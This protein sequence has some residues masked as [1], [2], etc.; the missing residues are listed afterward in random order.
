MKSSLTGA[1]RYSPSLRVRLLLAGVLVQTVM[2]ALLIVNGINVMD[3]KLTERTRA[4]LD[5]QR[6]FLR[7]VLAAPL[8][9]NDYATAQKV[10]EHVRREDGIAYLV[11][12]DASGRTVAASGWERDRVLPHLK[13]AAHYQSGVFDTAVQIEMDGR[14]HGMLRFGVS[15]AFM[16]NARAEL[17]RDNLAIGIVALILSI[18][19]L[20]GLSYWLTGSLVRLTRA[21]TQVAA[22][23]LDVQ[24]PVESDDEV[25]RLTHAF[26]TM[27]VALRERI[28]ALAESE[29]KFTAIADYSYDCELWIS[30]EGKLIWVNPR[31]FDMFGYTREECLATEN[32][33]AP[34]VS[35]ADV[36]RTVRQVQRAL[37]GNS[38]Q[39]YEFRARRKDGSEF[40]AAADWRPIYDARGGYLGIRISI[41]NIAQRKRA[42]QQLESTVAE[43]REA[44]SVQQEYLTRAQEEHAR[45]SALLGAMDIGILFVSTD[46]RVVYANPAFSRIWMIEPAARLI[47][48]TPEDVLSRSGCTLA[49]AE[50]QGRYV[51][52]KPE[53]GEA[54]GVLELQLADGRTITQQGYT[55]E[56]VGHRPVGYLWLFEDVTLERQTAAQLVY[57]AERDALTGLYNRHRFNDEL[58]RMIADAERNGTRIA[59]FF[60][61]LDDFKYIND[62]FG[63]RAGDA[64]LIRVAGEVGGQVRRNEIFARL[65]GDEFA[66]LVPDATDEMVSVLAERVTR[67]IALVRFQFE[68]Q[69]LRLTSS[70]GIAIF[71]DHADNVEDLISRADT[72]M[73]QAKDSGK[74][75]WRI[76]RS[77]LDTTLQMVS[78]LSWNE[79]IS[80]A[81]EHGLMDLQFQGIYSAGER[82]L[83][84]LEVLVRMRDKDDPA[85]FL[86]PGQFIPH[87]ERSGKILD[88]DRWVLR[89]SI[90]ML[91]EVPAI[92][93]LA[94]NISGRS[95]GE[96][97]LPQYIAEEL[98]K[99]SVSPPRLLVELTETS[100]VSD[101]HD[102]QRFIEALR[103]TGCGVSLDDFGTGFSSFAYL[104]YLQVDS[105]KIDGLFIRNLP[106]DYD[107]QLFV[108][109]IVSVARGLR[110]TTIAECVEDEETLEMLKVFGVDAVQGYYFE[111]PRS[112][113]PLLVTS[114]RARLSAAYRRA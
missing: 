52:K 42:E 78:R 35:G 82:T 50:E 47:D 107:N 16:Q 66:I 103:Q 98:R 68:G 112:D 48:S 10:L 22:G 102:A 19:S 106:S 110:R 26:N 74:N 15:T 36:A 94:V 40:W 54:L 55:V 73:Y 32:F 91:A 83:S 6:Q 105:V 2:L 85:S 38:G 84:H 109:A 86:M 108:K 53:A 89:E 24:L 72:A 93:G 3:Q 29:A 71:P 95:F 63:H 8:A 23:D 25:G 88:I 104:K 70:L 81:L 14:N 34:F 65:G 33:P 101:L 45:L 69:S 28:R 4:Q 1:R 46:D 99:R 57:L 90:Q 13:P 12:L 59:L 61:D 44:Q 62:T 87:A 5:E 80:H 111:K 30:P 100:A 17:V 41:R 9:A 31:V 58:G 113:H 67:S 37:S 21:S 7:A 27:A 20:V 79:R 75:A 49:R 96:P 114:S 56:D 97:A 77:D 39:D 60:F 76:Y 92:P 43:L 51:L 18:I 64:M 11:L